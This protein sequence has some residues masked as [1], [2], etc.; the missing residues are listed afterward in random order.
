MLLSQSDSLKTVLSEIGGYDKKIFYDIR[1]LRSLVSDL[2]VGRKIVLD[3]FFHFVSLLPTGDELKNI[4]GIRLNRHIAPFDV[5]S[6][7][8]YQYIRAIYV[9]K[10]YLLN[11]IEYKHNTAES[12]PY[13]TSIKAFKTNLLT[14]YIGDDVSLSWDVINPYKLM[15]SDGEHQMDVTCEK[16]VNI[17]AQK[18]LYTLFLYNE[19]NI[20]IDKRKLVL[21]LR[22]P[23]FCIFCGE[24][25]VEETDAYCC[26]CGTKL[27]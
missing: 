18:K 3:T 16:S 13:S 8:V 6:E 7:E 11:N 26:E 14:P 15:L 19:E 22:F 5:L 4:S 20:V 10:N 17:Y 23:V 25:F 2:Y 24:R 12:L 27:I 21:S 9:N 1:L